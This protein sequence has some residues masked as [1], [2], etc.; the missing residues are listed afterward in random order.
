M[1][2]DRMGKKKKIEDGCEEIRIHLKRSGEIIF[3]KLRSSNTHEPNKAIDLTNVI[4]VTEQKPIILLP[5]LTH[6]P[7]SGN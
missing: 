7:T 5:F 2:I 6:S 3:I 1:I 4:L